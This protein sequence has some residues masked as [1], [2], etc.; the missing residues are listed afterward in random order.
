MGLA[1][2]RAYRK[3]AKIVGE[4]MGNYPHGNMPIYD[5]LVRMAQDFNMRYPLIDGQGNY[6]SVT[7]DPP[8]AERYTEARMT[9]LAEDVG[10]HR[11]GHGRSRSELRRIA[12]GTPGSTDEGAESFDQW[13]GRHRGGLCHQHPHAQH[14]RNH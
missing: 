8:A 2:N 14:R 3:S 6:G 12:A 9:K 5:A 13:S 1:S 11:Q 4:V 10:R 7:G